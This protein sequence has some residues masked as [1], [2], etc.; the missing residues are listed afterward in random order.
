MWHFTPLRYTVPALILVVGAAFLAFYYLFELRLMEDRL[1]ENAERD[2]RVLAAVSAGDLEAAFRVDDQPQARA[3]VERLAGNR[4]IEVALFTDSLGRILYSTDAR[5]AGSSLSEVGDRTLEELFRAAAGDGQVVIHHWRDPDAV[6][7][8]FP[9]NMRTDPDTFLPQENGWL[10]IDTDLSQTAARLR[11]DLE[12]RMV[13]FALALGVLCVLLWLFFRTVLLKR[14]HRLA[15]TTRK[16]AKG[17][18]SDRPDIG[19]GDELADL[20]AEF[21]TMADHLQSRT[22]ELDFLA[23]HDSLTGLLNRRGMEQRLAATI[24]HVRH[25]EGRYLLCYL[26]IDGF[27]VINDTQGHAAGDAL[28]REVAATLR[29]GIASE[30]P[31]A[32]LA[33]DEFT[34][35]L[36][37]P[38]DR[39][40]RGAA[41][42]I[43]DLTREFRFD[44]GEERYRV[45]FNIGVVRLD[46]DT[47]SVEHVLSLADAAC[48]AAKASGHTRI[49][50]WDPGEE[51]LALQHGEMHWV[52]RI[53]SA[54]DQ[55]RLELQAQQIFPARGPQGLHLEMLVRMR[56]ADGSLIP[57]DRFLPAAEHYGLVSQIDRW[58]L[59]EAFAYFRAHP[60]A[61][62][63]LDFCA[64]NLSALSLGNRE[65][66]DLVAREME[67]PDG[68]DPGQLCLEVT[69]TAAVT[70][71]NVAAGFMAEMREL[72]CRF[73][74]D[75]FGSG[76][77]SFGYLRNLEVELI[78][79]DGI[80]VRG[81]LNDATDL[82]IVRSINEIAHEMG[83]L[84]VAEFV[85]SRELATAMRQIGIDYLQGNGLGRTGPLETV[86]DRA[87]RKR[88]KRRG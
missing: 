7:G 84:T 68:L 9:I 8:A 61:R 6:A 20:A 43:Q 40:A 62:E 5:L 3:A 79:I 85:E 24:D 19:E 1:H 23:T 60:E 50:V 55:D 18:Y 12:Q 22:E 2:L 87:I 28:L 69:E 81:V 88:G 42:A 72:G 30:A 39:D 70:N 17:D 83:K 4:H 66:V 34:V 67:S 53:Q 49:R 36:P 71:L 58:V 14:I 11:R 46:R 73:A 77:S 27:R 32:R 65:L 75:D 44:W 59:N 64:V 15:V 80:F 38:R 37:E 45:A 31:M 82:A 51:E 48:Y 13:P 56:D 16:L 76:V 54:L 63:R 29:R 21:R 35:L 10:L 52:G 47:E 25:S 86:L 41:Q 57:P 74:L 78:K 33:G 26:D